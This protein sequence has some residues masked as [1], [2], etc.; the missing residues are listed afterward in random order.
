MTVDSSKIIIFLDTIID[1][2]GFKQ[3][4]NENIPIFLTEKSCFEFDF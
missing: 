3:I 4:K 1:F 2:F